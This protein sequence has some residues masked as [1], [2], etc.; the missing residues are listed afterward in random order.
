MSNYPRSL[1]DLCNVVDRKVG[2]ELDQGTVPNQIDV[3]ITRAYDDKVVVSHLGLDSS[4]PDLN[5][6]FHAV[7]EIQGDNLQQ[8]YA[9][10]QENI[11][12]LIDEF[13]ASMIQFTKD[14]NGELSLTD[15]DDSVILD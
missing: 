6:M 3:V 7:A 4:E 1:I 15:E 8:V 10:V 5:V 2:E 13:D 12:N 14:N 11:L 9:G